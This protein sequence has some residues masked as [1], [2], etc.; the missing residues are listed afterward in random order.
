MRRAL[1]LAGLGVTV[2]GL[3]SSHAGPLATAPEAIPAASCLRKISLDL[4]HRGP[5]EA[6]LAALAAGTALDTLADVY[7]GSP[8]F[9]AVVFDW[10]RSQFPPTAVTPP[11][12]DVEEPS[13]IARHIVVNDLDYRTIVTGGFTIDATGAEQPRA[14]RPAA[15]VLSTPHY[16]SAFVGRYRRSWSGRFLKEWG[17]IRLTPI[18]LAPEDARDLS[19]TSLTVDPACAGCHADPVHGVD[20]LAAFAFCWDEH[21]DFAEGCVEPSASFLTVS[22]SGLA[23]LGELVADSNEFKMTAINFFFEQLFG[24]PLAFG[25]TA[26][27]IRASGAFHASGYQAKALI[28]NL[29]T[30]PEYCAQ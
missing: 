26:L 18:T 15:G 20:Y 27:F 2:A 28:R 12:V 19:P 3:G 13:R 22:G 30:S 23:A 14:E 24:R 25:E 8:E 17:G 5:T 9:E 29:V 7:L 11:D 21:G 1:V 16:L 4:V 6:E 10:Y